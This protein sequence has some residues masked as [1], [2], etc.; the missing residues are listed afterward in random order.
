MKIAYFIIG[1]VLLVSGVSITVW[2]WYD[3]STTGHYSAGS[4]YIGPVLV[5]L[6]LLRMVRAAA[7]VP[8]PA[9]ARL[10]II[11]LAILC[12]YGNAAAIKSAYPQAFVDDAAG[13]TPSNSPS[14]STTPNP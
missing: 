9:V 3:V 8:L 2:T 11:G 12:G 10:A 7:A 4:A 13:S 6:G 1:I 14:V 5:I